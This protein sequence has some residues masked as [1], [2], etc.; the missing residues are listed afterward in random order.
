[1]GHMVMTGSGGPE[2]RI[3]MTHWGMGMA[4]IC[5]EGVLD[6]TR[7]LLEPLRFYVISSAAL[8]C[9]ALRCGCCSALTG[10]RKGRNQMTLSSSQSLVL[11]IH[12]SD[13][14]DPRT[15]R[16]RH[17]IISIRPQAPIPDHIHSA[18]ASERSVSFPLS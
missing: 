11:F 15:P 3:L 5:R 9:V 1:M 10:I 12:G 6:V 18:R 17:P 14:M 8:R 13:D 16:T 2:R 4:G 7:V